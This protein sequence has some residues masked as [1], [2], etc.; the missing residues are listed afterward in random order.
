LV[1]QLLYGKNV[2]VNVLTKENGGVNIIP[3]A[4]RLLPFVSANEINF[5]AFNLPS[6]EYHNE[7]YEELK[8]RDDSS[9]TQPLNIKDFDTTFFQK[10][11]MESPNHPYNGVK[12]QVSI[13]THLRTQIHHRGTAGRANIEE[14]K[15]SI[16]TM[17]GFLQS[18][19]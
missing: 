15:Q 13:H 5:L 16:K 17:R 9:R 6:E 11:K 7:L 4:D 12:N 19:K 3:I 1:K 8:V 18:T 14:I 10:Q 2:K